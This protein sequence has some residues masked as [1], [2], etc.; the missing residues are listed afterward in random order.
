MPN[1]KF[2]KYRGVTATAGTDWQNPEKLASILTDRS[3][4]SSIPASNFDEQISILVN[5]CEFLYF[6]PIFTVP[7][8]LSDLVVPHPCLE[9]YVNIVSCF[10]GNKQ[11]VSLFILRQ[12]LKLPVLL[13]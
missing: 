2:L 7:L 1:F 6:P 9:A 10:S 8:S 4:F 5:I 12:S 11:P 3:D 13:L